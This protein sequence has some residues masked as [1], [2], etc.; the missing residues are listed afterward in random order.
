MTSILVATSRRA[1]PKTA[2]HLLPSSSRSSCRVSPPFAYFQLRETLSRKHDRRV[3]ST[4]KVETGWMVPRGQSKTTLKR[5]FC[6]INYTIVITRL[7]ATKWLIFH[8]C[9]SNTSPNTGE[10]PPPPVTRKCFLGYRSRRVAQATAVVC[11]ATAP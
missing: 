2:T 7:R 4:W 3:S 11:L 9:S 8:L 1:T 5:E 10:Y 6:Q